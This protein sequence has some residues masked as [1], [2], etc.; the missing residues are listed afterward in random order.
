MRGDECMEVSLCS[1]Y[2]GV[3]GVSG[4]MPGEGN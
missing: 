4:R 3:D 1:V 2:K